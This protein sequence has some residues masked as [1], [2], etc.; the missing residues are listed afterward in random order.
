LL[1]VGFSSS[2]NQLTL[3]D[4]GTVLATNI[5][6]G[7]SSGYTGNGISVSGGN[8]YAT[9]AAAT[10][11]LEV[12]R[13][14]LHT[15]GTTV[16]NGT[17]FVVGDGTSAATLDLL[18]GTHTFANGLSISSNATL[19]GTGTLLAP[20]TVSGTF[21]PGHSP[22][23]LTLSNNL[24][25]ADN[26]IFLAELRGYIAGAEYD[27]VILTGLLTNNN[28]ALILSLLNGFTPTNGSQFVLFD[29]ANT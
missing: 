25:L 7:Y 27:Q 10:A 18:T 15:G 2:G 8:L 23:T 26:S 1:L 4:S 13:G 5:I 29:N 21:S 11:L 3:T 28:A 9:N 22:G 6:I 14:T 24:T 20:L 17:A 12:R 19:T 16:S